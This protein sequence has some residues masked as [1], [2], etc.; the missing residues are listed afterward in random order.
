MA[1]APPGPSWE[2]RLRAA[3]RRCFPISENTSRLLVL[4]WLV[5]LSHHQQRSIRY[6]FRKATGDR[7]GSLER[8]AGNAKLP[9]DG[10][11]WQRDGAEANVAPWGKATPSEQPPWRP[12]AWSCGWRRV[13]RGGRALGAGPALLASAG[14]APRPRVVAY[15]STVTSVLIEGIIGWVRCS[16]RL[17]V[18]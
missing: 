15:S 10:G 5:C 2:S 11:A 13:R 9:R 1:S 17:G 7:R 4:K 16:P 14:T 3:A 8:W 6:T 18:L 12:G